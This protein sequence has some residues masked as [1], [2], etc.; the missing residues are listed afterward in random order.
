GATRIR[1]GHA[2]TRGATG[3]HRR[4]SS[5]FAG[6]LWSPA[7]TDQGQGQPEAV[8]TGLGTGPSGQMPWVA[9]ALGVI[10][11]R[12]VQRYFSAYGALHAVA[13]GGPRRDLHTLAH[14]HGD[15]AGK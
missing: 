14:R 11:I 12:R 13:A 6:S 4:R 15:V 10:P 3:S 1:P 5:V 2:P 9:S 8:S 7:P